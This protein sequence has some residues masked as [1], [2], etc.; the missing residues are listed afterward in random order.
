M[1]KG[2][3]WYKSK[4]MFVR[5]NKEINIEYKDVFCVLKYSNSS[6]DVIFTF[7]HLKNIFEC[8]YFP[9]TVLGALDTPVSQT[10]KDDFLQGTSRVRQ[11]IN[12][13]YNE[14]L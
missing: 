5:R 3:L 10:C 6:T 2:D 12:R 4:T 8:H 1:G 11:V 9:A 7:T 14:I 13:K